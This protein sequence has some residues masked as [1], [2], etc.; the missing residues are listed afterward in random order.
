MAAGWFHVRSIDCRQSLGKPTPRLFSHALFKQVGKQACSTH[1]LSTR[2]VGP[3]IVWRPVH[4]S[5]STGLRLLRHHGR[6]LKLPAELAERGGRAYT[7][8]RLERSP[9]PYRDTAEG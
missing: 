5:A 3:M 6:R 2:G 9:R 8:S 7:A 1:Q 4:T